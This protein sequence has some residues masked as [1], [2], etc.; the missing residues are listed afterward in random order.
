M[1]IV[2]AFSALCILLVVGKILRVTIRR[3]PAG[4]TA[5]VGAKDRRSNRVSPSVQPCV[6]ESRRRYDRRDS[7]GLRTPQRQGRRCPV[8]R[9]RFDLLMLRRLPS[10][11]WGL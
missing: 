11:I 2:L 5:V 9:A 10:T 6:G 4:K 8:K 3:G 7:T 1:D